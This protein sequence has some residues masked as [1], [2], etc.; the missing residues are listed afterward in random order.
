MTSDVMRPE[1]EA[2][3]PEEA[4]VEDVV[5]KTLHATPLTTVADPTHK[6]EDDPSVLPTTP[7]VTNAEL[8]DTMLISA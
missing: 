7:N 8:L 4:M 5:L 6:K 1:D 2:A 3:T